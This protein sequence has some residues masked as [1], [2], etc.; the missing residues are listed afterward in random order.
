MKDRDIQFAI[1]VDVRMEQ[2][3]DKLKLRRPH[4]IVF[5]NFELSL[6]ISNKIKEARRVRS[7][8]TDKSAHYRH[9]IE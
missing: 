3:A 7:C 8:N 4:R 5:Q 2:R 9:K 1:R 6:E